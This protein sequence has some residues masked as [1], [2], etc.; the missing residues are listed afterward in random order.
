[1]KKL[2]R[3]AFRL[4]QQA[5]LDYI[6][7]IRHIT[8]LSLNEDFE[9]A[10]SGDGPLAGL[11]RPLEVVRIYKD[12]REEVIRGLQFVGVTR[13]T[14]KDIVL[15]GPQGNTVT[16]LDGSHGGDIY[17]ISPTSGILSTWYVPAVLVA[18]VELKGN[19]G[20]EPHVLSPP[21][22]TKK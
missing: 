17:S 12:G 4:A 8:P 1:M 21:P 7:H 13:N 10:F 5:D 14:L 16:V 22:M 20:K 18:E 9:I 11:T 3:K 15:A 2:Q 6:L 19:T